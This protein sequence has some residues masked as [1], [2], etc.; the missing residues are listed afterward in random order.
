MLKRRSADL[1]TRRCS[2]MSE[3]AREM[4]RQSGKES[5]MS[6]RTCPDCVETI[7]EAKLIQTSLLPIHGFRNESVDI[8]FRFIPLLR[9]GGRLCRLLPFTGRSHRNLPRG[10]GRESLSAAMFA[11][12]VM[13]TLRGIHESGTDTARVLF[14][15]NERLVRRP[16]RGTF[17]RPCTLF[18]TLSLGNSSSPMPGCHCHCW[19]PEARAGS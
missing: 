2:G 10:R 14:L 4:E 15:L 18:S 16:I 5:F 1:T 8:A 17:V 3:L 12:L 7:R 6:G 11:A 19:S 13:G 9:R